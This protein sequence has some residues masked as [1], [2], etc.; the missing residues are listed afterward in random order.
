VHLAGA[1]A[2]SGRRHAARPFAIARH[3][4]CSL[5]GHAREVER[6]APCDRTRTGEP[7]VDRRG[8]PAHRKRDPMLDA[9]F[10]VSAVAFFAVA[11]AYVAGCDA[12]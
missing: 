12:L 6:A 5:A 11:L 4:G 1:R 8:R 3:A 2:G 10:I 9:V 7:P